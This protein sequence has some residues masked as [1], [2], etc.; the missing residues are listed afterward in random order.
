MFYNITVVPRRRTHTRLQTVTYL[1]TRHGCT[2]IRLDLPL[3]HVMLETFLAD[4]GDV[5]EEELES[6]AVKLMDGIGAS[7][8]KIYFDIL[9]ARYTPSEKCSNF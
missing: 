4:L 5:P 7:F 3:M 2:C 6:F 8:D 9:Q 1:E